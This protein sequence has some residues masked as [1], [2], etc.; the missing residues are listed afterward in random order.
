M[1]ERDR[2]SR[3]SV[4]ACEAVSEGIGPIFL[5]TVPEAQ[6]QLAPKMFGQVDELF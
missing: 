6:V 4:I 1:S 2:W 3:S 5:V